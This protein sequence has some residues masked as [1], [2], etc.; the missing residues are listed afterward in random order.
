MQAPLTHLESM[1]NPWRLM[2]AFFEIKS[3][4]SRVYQ[5]AILPENTTWLFGTIWGNVC[6]FGGRK[7]HSIH[8]LKFS[9]YCDFSHHEYWWALNHELHAAKF[10]NI[11]GEQRWV[12]NGSPRGRMNLRTHTIK[13]KSRRPGVKHL[14]LK[15]AN[16]WPL[17]RAYPRRV[18]SRK[19]RKGKID[20]C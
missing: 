15:S 3:D 7:K 9:F 1:S 12:V 18:A 10:T 16:T 2:M 13:T 17:S 5:I 14:W 20:T 8:I 6:G 4:C 19:V 11:P